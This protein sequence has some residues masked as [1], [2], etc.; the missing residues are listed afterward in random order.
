MNRV[1]L[2]ITMIATLGLIS[3]DRPKTPKT[4]QEKY[5]YSIGYQFAKNLKQQSVD[6]DVDSLKQA[7]LDVN[8]GK[9]SQVEEAEM[10]RV[11]QAMYEER[12]KKMNAEAGDN[13]KKGQDWLEA[14]KSKEGVKVTASGCSTKWFRRAAA[15]S[16]RIRMSWLSITRALCS[17][18][19]SSIARSSAVSPRNFR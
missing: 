14:N 16:L 12:S 19:L 8:K 13:L 17:M 1:L 11:M 10:Q 4:D 5:S 18:E 2:A 15:R 7:I 6:Y 9:E 3:C